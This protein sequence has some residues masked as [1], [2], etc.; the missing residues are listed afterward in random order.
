MPSTGTSIELSLDSER[1][2]EYHDETLPADICKQAEFCSMCGPKH[3]P[4]Q[5][6]IT[7]KELEI[8]E[9]PLNNNAKAETKIQQV[10]TIA[11]IE[12]RKSLFKQS[13]SMIE[14][15][16]RRIFYQVFR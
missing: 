5:I 14:I 4:M 13:A 2:K 16:L 6:K 9:S 12:A 8:L 3:G 15:G 7:N 10:S 11:A 1:A